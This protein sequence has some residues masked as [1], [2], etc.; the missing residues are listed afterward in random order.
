MEKKDAMKYW[1]NTNN[2]AYGFDQAIDMHHTNEPSST[3]DLAHP[4]YYNYHA[5]PNH[6]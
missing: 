6:H 4:Y 1:V 5:I 2:V 3:E